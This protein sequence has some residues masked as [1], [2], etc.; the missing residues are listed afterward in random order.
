MK[1]N[2]ENVIDNTLQESDSQKDR[3]SLENTKS[4]NLINFLNNQ[5]EKSTAKN[6]LRDDVISK[7]KNKI[8][9]KNDEVP[10]LVLIRLLEIL[11]RAD[12]DLTLGILSSMKEAALLKKLTG[13]G[14]GGS[15]KKESLEFNAEE[16]DKFKK[17]LSYIENVD[18]A[19]GK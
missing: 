5:I 7:L 11:E 4:L 12:N 1:N 8:S 6:K 17:I 14:V 16:L 10:T 19:E 3:G 9:N 13:E 2:I 18:T 15:E